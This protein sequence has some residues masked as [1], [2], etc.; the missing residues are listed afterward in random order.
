M[1]KEHWCPVFTEYLWGARLDFLVTSDTL[2]FFPNLPHT[3]I[4]LYMS[5][6]SYLRVTE[7]DSGWIKEKRN[8]LI[9]IGF[10]SESPIWSENWTP[11]L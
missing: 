10:A 2:S 5:Q 8:K 11:K 6:G 3:G 1:K 4:R 7:T 9:N